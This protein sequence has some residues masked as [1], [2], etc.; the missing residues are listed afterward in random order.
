MIANFPNKLFAFVLR[1]VIVFPLGRPYVVPSDKLG[2]QV[3]ALLL[4]PSPTRDRLTSDVHLSSDVEEPIG[5][6]EAAL[7][8]T[9]AA[10]P[11]DA[12]LKDARRQGRF[13][14]KVLA[15]GD[16]DEIWRLALHA[17]V[18]SEQEFALVERR[19]QLRDKVIRVDDFPY[20]FGLKSVMRKLHGHSPA[21]DKVAE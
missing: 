16:V 6:L 12:K 19:N 18:I 3:A 11:V 10:D 2:H 9:L 4:E 21:Q 17:G 20:D 15:A 7:A 5:A 13:D 14:P 8:A 1:S